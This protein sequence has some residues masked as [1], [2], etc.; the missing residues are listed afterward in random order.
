MGTSSL[1]FQTEFVSHEFETTV[2]EGD[3]NDFLSVLNESIG[4]LRTQIDDSTLESILRA[5][6]GSYKLR[7]TMTR[8]NL[9]PEPFTQDALVEP[10]FDVLGYDTNP[11]A[12]TLSSD[13]GERADYTVSLRDYDNIDTTRLLIETEP[14]NKSLD[15]RGHG[16]NQVESW[17]SQREFESDYGFATDGLRWIFIRYDPDAYT[18]NRIES[19]DLSDIVLELFE[20]ATGTS[21]P[22]EEVISESQYAVVERVLDTFAHNNFVKIASEAPQVIKETQKAITDEFYDDY[23]RYVFG[24][25]DKEKADEKTSRSLTGDGIIAP[26]E[27]DGEDVRRFAVDLMN[28]LIFIKFLEDKHIVE[29]DLL[30]TLKSTYEDGVYTDTFYETFIE[31]LFFGVMNTKPKERFDQIKEI[32][33]YSDIPYLNGGLFRPTLG[34]DDDDGVDAYDLDVRNTILFSITELLE[35]YDFSADGGPTDLD[36]SVLG[37]VFEKTINYLTSDSDGSKELG[38]YYTPKEITR[39]SAE[40]TVHPALLERIEI[41]LIE[42]REW[43]EQEV[44]GHNSVYEIIDKLPPKTSLITGILKDVIDQ[45]RVVDPACGSGHYLTSVLEEIVSI[46][47]ALYARQEFYPDLYQ[48]RKTTVQ[49]NIYGVDIVGPAV[50]IA[51]L[52]C[53]LAIITD[54]TQGDVEDLDQEELA[55]PNIAFNLRQ[56]NSLIGFTG[57]PETTDDGDYTFE[58]FSEGSVRQ[59]YQ[60]IITEI[61]NYEEAGRKGF[62]EK[63]ERHRQNATGLL[64]KYRAELNTKITDEFLEL[65][66]DIDEET[67]REDYGEQ[68]DDKIL[69]DI[70]EEINTNISEDDITELDTFHWILEFAEV[71]SHGGF[72][73]VVGNPPWEVLMANREDY[74]SKFDA[75]FRTRVLDQKDERQREL[76]EEKG[77]AKGWIEY[78][79]RREILVSYFKESQSYDLQSPDIGGQARPDLSML[80]MERVFSL[81][82]ENGYTAK[83]IP[84]KLF[85]GTGSKDLRNHLLSKT[86]ISHIVGFENK[87]IFDG[88]DNRYKFGAVTFKN[89]GE[90][91]Q[92]HCKFLNRDT[93]VLQDVE[94]ETFAVPVE[95]LRDY[96]PRTAIYPQITREEEIPLLEKIVKHPPINDPSI[97]GWYVDL[98]KEELNRSRDSDRFIQDESEGD[99]PVYGGGN[100]WQYAHNN[101]FWDDLSA[102]TLW[103]VDEDVD[104][105]LSAKRRVRNKNFRRLKKAIY[106]EFDGSGSQIG[107]IDDLLKEHRGKE[108]SKADV[109]L[110]CTGYR[111]GIRQIAN[112]TNERSCIA[113]VLPPGIVTHNKCPTIRP[114]EINPTEEDIKEIP[115]HGV[116]DR[117]FTDEELFALL[118]ILNSVP[119]DYI[120]RTK[121]D[122]SLSMNMFEECQAPRM[123]EDDEWFEFISTRAARLNGYG[124]EFEDMRK[125]LDG[126]DPEDSQA[127]RLKLQAEVDAAVFH[128]YGFSYE[129]TEF[130]LE[131]FHKVQSPRVMTD[132][133]FDTVLS[134][135][136]TVVEQVE[137]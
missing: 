93:D 126:L 80:F 134:K 67:I 30:R 79:R 13:R 129:E 6:A 44:T 36:P 21:D 64:K 48:L 20:N 45:F 114:Y 99:Y 123:T 69:D 110:D 39:Y 62:P 42:E 2:T 130:I 52:R 37:N 97:E 23:I 86:E 35:N 57:F 71:Y 27:A 9:Q 53:W 83:L 56:G 112:N 131:D 38:A 16:V 82:D 73:V 54:L 120:V 101:V 22:I 127:N 19:V 25:V 49:K 103:S 66:V 11:E 136:E 28:R 41:Y 115:A 10:L 91:T 24:V 90:T 96:S 1:D 109:L 3:I 124:D 76:L 31:K 70:T 4:R 89:S 85:T 105:E 92:L 107:F 108:S 61:E 88:I 33:F 8:D 78:Q 117:I 81:T 72:D 84:G 17:L 95:V 125:R 128:A 26:D 118:G 77:I 102:P 137:H 5:E 106:T 100:I 32:D 87:G 74:F 18:H 132:D 29:P 121:L 7:E 113:A 116:Y 50:E 63:A 40:E 133:Y 12:S 119:F 46:R 60:D 98:Y 122:T 75:R 135:Y 104:P 34:N 65:D 14:I 94:K 68:I 55:L 51:K 111:I 59:R 15:S 58:S 43:P 47:R